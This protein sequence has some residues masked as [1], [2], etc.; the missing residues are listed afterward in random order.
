M[1]I[2]ILGVENASR[3]KLENM[4][5]SAIEKLSVKAEVQI[6]GEV[7]Q[8]LKHNI[9]GIPALMVDDQI[10]SQKLVPDE[11]KLTSIFSM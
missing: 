1:K 4:V 11:T 8:I 6:V 9:T 2:K 3:K 10:I 5:Q 7:D